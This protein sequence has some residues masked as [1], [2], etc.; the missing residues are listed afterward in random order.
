MY[1][2]AALQWRHN[3]HNGV[4]NHRRLRCLLSCSFRR[5]SKKTSKLRV[6]GLCAGIHRWPHKRPLTRKIFPFGGV[7]MIEYVKYIL[8]AVLSVFVRFL[9]IFFIAYS[10]YHNMHH[11]FVE[12][13]HISNWAALVF[14]WK[15]NNSLLWFTLH[16]LR[17]IDEILC[18]ATYFDG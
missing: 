5:R 17:T 8:I 7:I 2:Q 4:S 3:E 14:T 18:I 13:I 15:I 6:I 16:M 9:H 12:R 11:I 10:F 1:H